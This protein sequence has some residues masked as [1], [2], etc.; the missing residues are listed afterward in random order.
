MKMK[1]DFFDKSILIVD[2][3]KT[4]IVLLESL[5]KDEGYT[6]VYSVTSAKEAYRVLEE[7]TIHLIL[8]D[9]LMPDINGIDAC[10]TITSN[11]IYKAI[12]IIMVT[13]DTSD[14]TLKQSFEA[15]AYDFITKP[16][17]VINLHVRIDS[18]FLNLQK[19]AIILNQNRRL[20]INDTVKMLAHQWRQPLAAISASTIDILLSYDLD[21]LTV[22]TIKNSTDTINRSL[23]LL[24]KT[25]DDFLI[26]TKIE[27]NEKVCNIN[28]TIIETLEMM[29]G[30]FSA[31]AISIKSDFSD[32]EEI[33][34]F[35]NELKKILVNIYKNS[36]EAFDRMEIEKEKNIS[37]STYQIEK[38][39]YISIED[40]AGGVDG[41]II[42][43]IFEPYISIKN[44]KN[45]VGLGL[46]N[47][48]NILQNLFNASIDVSSKEEKT[49][50]TIKINIQ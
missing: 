4:N 17:N 5:L 2:D 11:P 48:Q 24:T 23:Q 50:F 22:D 26:F 36:I 9:I 38:I 41:S 30:Y 35:V 8:L 47:A 40:N 27:E 43:K 21:E 37:V 12:P 28:E 20:A 25:I 32:L 44:E 19:D 13:A 34:C 29:D 16:I 6:T 15:G 49:I 7:N 33:S 45:G 42:D 39:I 1:K 46:Y 31:N 3:N 18:A 10:K 14:N